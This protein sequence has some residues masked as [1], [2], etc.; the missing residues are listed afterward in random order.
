MIN[1]AAKL[2]EDIVDFMTSCSF[3]ILEAPDI[4]KLYFAN[5]I[6]SEIS[7]AAA[8]DQVTTTWDSVSTKLTRSKVEAGITLA[9]QM[10]N[11]FANAA[12][13][14]ADYWSTIQALTHADGGTGSFVASA[15][16]ESLGLRLR[17]FGE[18]CLTQFNRAKAIQ[19]LYYDNEFGDI[20]SVLDAERIIP[21]AD[22]TR[23][24][25]ANAVTLVAQF[26]NLVG[27]AAVTTGD[28]ESTVSKWK[29]Y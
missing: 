11:F 28:Y 26:Q 16:L 1:L 7:G 9:Q 13:T 3:L 2:Q 19:N 12:V 25:L 29:A 27:N 14:Q 6:N 24:D 15:S 17:R 5:A 18:D 10:N 23:N 21:G 22:M 8:G 4:E 20:V